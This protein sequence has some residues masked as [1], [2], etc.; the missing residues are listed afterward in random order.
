MIFRE[1]FMIFWSFFY[2]SPQPGG[3]KCHK[4]LGAVLFRL[5]GIHPGLKEGY[6]GAQKELEG[7]LGL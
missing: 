6:L 7:V 3:P 4:C 2:S 1:F 5:F